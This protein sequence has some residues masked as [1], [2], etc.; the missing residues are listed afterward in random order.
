MFLSDSTVLD[1]RVCYFQAKATTEMLPSLPDRRPEPL[2]AASLLDG[3]A[4]ITPS[5]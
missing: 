5:P 2:M 3:G 1:N 4:S